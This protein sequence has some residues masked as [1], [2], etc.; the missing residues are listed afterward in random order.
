MY[1]LV[2]MTSDR[3]VK[4]KPEV[5]HKCVRA[6]ER[7]LALTHEQAEEALSLYNKAHAMADPTL[8]ARTFGATLPF[9]PRDLRQEPARW[10]AVHDWLHTR[11]V[12]K[13]KLRLKDLFTNA[14]VPKAKAGNK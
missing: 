6:Y 7:R 5:V 11:G 2:V 10:K 9:F 13:K 3:M 12:I 1:Q 4:Q 14:F 8:S